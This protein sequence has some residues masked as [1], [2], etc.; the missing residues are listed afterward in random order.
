MSYERRK[1]G[2][3]DNA[4]ST[5]LGRGAASPG[6][7][8][9][10]GALPRERVATPSSGASEPSAVNGPPREW[11]L[12]NFMPPRTEMDGDP[13]GDSS[14]VEA[15]AEAGRAEGSGQGYPAVRLQSLLEAAPTSE[16]ADRS[17]RE[18][19]GPAAGNVQAR[20][21]GHQMNGASVGGNTE[22]LDDARNRLFATFAASMG[23]SET[24]AW[25]ALD[26]SARA[27][28]L[29]VTHR[30]GGSRL[31]NGDS[32]L[33]H[34]TRVHAIH[35][36]GSDGKASGGIDNNRVFFSMDDQLY[37][38]LVSV[39]ETK[40]RQP[41]VT[42]VAGDV[43]RESHDKKPVIGWLGVGGPHKPFDMSDETNR[44]GPRA[45]V[46]FFKP[47]SRSRNLPLGRPGV[48]NIVDPNALEVDMDYNLRHDS[49]P[50]SR[51]DGEV[52]STMY[53]E[54]FGDPQLDWKPARHK[55]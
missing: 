6:K 47:G 9:R 14:A 8:T 17:R 51:Y 40:G 24:E 52:G 50:L 25:D 10:T 32:M 42:D 18:G 23:L 22:G 54:K 46:Q 28:F 45:Q 27:V 55:K 13:V 33:S 36:G 43:W 7:R 26:E 34:I 3:P 53:T 1:S 20:M 21:D 37:R 35:G 38:T 30:L 44:G 12:G 15:G 4:E 49:N 11:F 5:G 19:G 2:G 48:E 41:L 16:P 29:T 39:F 31:A